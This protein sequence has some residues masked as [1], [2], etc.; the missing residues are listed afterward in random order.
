M[1]TLNYNNLKW[2]L[3]KLNCLIFNFFSLM[4]IYGSAAIPCKHGMAR[5]FEFDTFFLIKFQF[6]IRLHYLVW[7]SFL[8]TNWYRFFD[9]K[10][11]SIQNKEKLILIIQLH[12]NKIEKIKLFQNIINDTYIYLFIVRK[13][14]KICNSIYKKS[15]FHY[16]NA[17]G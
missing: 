15:N 7:K 4:K 17:L 9:R 8:K 14:E 2:F 5:S 16:N 12:S 1:L 6:A 13:K 10:Y 11:L 3:Q